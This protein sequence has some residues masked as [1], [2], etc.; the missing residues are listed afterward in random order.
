MTLS[1][2]AQL[3]EY[4]KHGDWQAWNIPTGYKY[5]RRENKTV[6]LVWDWQA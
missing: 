2:P 3:T 6:Y 4:F 5:F 1:L